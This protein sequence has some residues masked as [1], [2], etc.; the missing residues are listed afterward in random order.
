MSK[1]IESIIKKLPAQRSPRSE[2]SLANS[3]KLLK[4]NFFLSFSKS[5]ILA[6]LRLALLFYQ[7]QEGTLQKRKLEII[8]DEHRCKILNKL[9]AKQIQQHSKKGPSLETSGIDPKT[10]SRMIHQKQIN[11]CGTSQ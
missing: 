8:P 9:L 3:I 11:K 10:I 6:N 5:S 2:V 7:I 4:Q 1:G